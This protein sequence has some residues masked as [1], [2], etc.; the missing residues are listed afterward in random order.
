[1]SDKDAEFR[2]WL[3]EERMLNPETITRDRTKKEFAQYVEDYN[4]GMFNPSRLFTILL[5]MR[6]LCSN[7]TSF[8][9]LFPST[10]HSS[11]R[12]SRIGRDSPA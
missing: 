7:L 4:T 2:A 5:L 1:M 10:L 11:T 3:V 6:N 12:P 8:K 9:I